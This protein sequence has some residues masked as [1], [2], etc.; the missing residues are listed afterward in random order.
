MRAGALYARKFCEFATPLQKS[1]RTIAMAN[2]AF[3]FLVRAM[4]DYN[5]TT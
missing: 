4:T 2:V 5:L 1:P 3:S